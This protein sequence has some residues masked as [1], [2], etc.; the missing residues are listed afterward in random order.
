VICID[1]IIDSIFKDV[2]EW[3]NNNNNKELIKEYNDFKVKYDDFNIK[4][5][6]FLKTIKINRSV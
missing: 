1:K 6:K 2:S 4:Y 5:E 3:K